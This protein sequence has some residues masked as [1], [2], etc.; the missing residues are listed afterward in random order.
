MLIPLGFI[1]K[2]P[3]IPLGFVGDNE[4]MSLIGAAEDLVNKGE[5]A[6]LMLGWVLTYIKIMFL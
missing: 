3:F 2:S 6:E 4:L 1:K 5:L